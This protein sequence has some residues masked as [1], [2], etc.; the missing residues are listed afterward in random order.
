MLFVLALLVL[1]LSILILGVLS[2]VFNLSPGVPFLGGFVAALI[3]LPS[4]ALQRNVQ[5]RVNRVLYGSHYDFSTV[6]AGFSSRL[7]VTLDRNALFELL[8]RDLS[9]QMGIQQSALFLADGENLVLQPAQGETLLMPL[10]DVVSR[11]LLDACT[12]VRS[13]YLWRAVPESSQKPWREY[14]WGELFVP[15]V[16]EGQLHGILI[17][18]ERVSADVYSDTDVQIIATTDTGIASARAAFISASCSRSFP[19]TRLWFRY[20]RMV[21]Q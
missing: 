15:M 5:V 14:D 6:T 11:F 13:Q 16:F 12:P 17:L 8:T 4:A 3:A 7:A 1:T 20:S 21:C 9:T 10:E 19:M 18:G 2:L